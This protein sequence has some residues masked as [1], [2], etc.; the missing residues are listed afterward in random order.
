MSSKVII[1]GAAVPSVVSSEEIKTSTSAEGLVAKYTVK[2]VDPPLSDVVPAAAV[3]MIA[4]VSMSS[5][6]MEN[7][8]VLGVTLASY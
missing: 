2:V 5:L 3:A 6:V 7:D 4:A 8:V 1:A